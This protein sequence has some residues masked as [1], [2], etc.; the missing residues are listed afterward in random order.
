MIIFDAQ[1][2][3]SRIPALDFELLLSA[4]I[5][6]PKEF[7][8]THP[9]YKLSFLETLRLKYFVFLYKRGYSVAAITSHKEFYGLDFFVNKNV[10]IPR[11]ETELMVE[12]ALEEIKKINKEITLVDVGTGSGCIPIAI[13]CHAEF[14]SAS[15]E[16]PRQVRNDMRIYATDIS[17]E[18]L[19]VAKKN[20]KKHNVKIK[21][22]RGNL[23]ESILKRHSLPP[24]PYSMI[25]TANL[26]YLTERQFQTEP[27][28]QREPK[29]ALVADNGGLALYEEL[30]Q[31]TK[32]LPAPNSILLLLEIDPSQ[33]T[34]IS[35]L[36]K[37]YFSNAAF[38][39]KNDLAGRDRLVILEI[40]RTS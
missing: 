29:A 30:F 36:I 27:S 8:F 17:R 5:K 26:P 16:I 2:K 20:A 32:L 14:I 40:A 7:L 33:S 10:L 9:E 3:Y 38:Q 6:K 25:I 19:K 39:I 35:K 22:L 11:P 18:A 34:G 24:A 12:S 28:I 1:K 37:K 31:Q 23:L 21:F 4:A 13:A 15:Q